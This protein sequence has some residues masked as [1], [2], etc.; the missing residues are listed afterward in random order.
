MNT[1]QEVFSLSEVLKGEQI[2]LAT[3]AYFRQRLRNR[4]YQLVLTEF[5]E[6]AEKKKLTKVDLARR[7]GRP[8]P[9]QITR[10]LAAPGNWTID[11]ISDLMLAM[12]TEPE[13]G[14]TYLTNQAKR[15]F[16]GP[17]W[18]NPRGDF[19]WISARQRA[20]SQAQPL[21]LPPLALRSTPQPLALTNP[22]ETK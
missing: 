3:L 4:L 20:A 8:T 12:G 22:L 10:W 1:S 15:N 9:S 18:L 21:P 16:D 11:T 2:S 14:V 19:D 5:L 13:L 7:I 6:Q 17:D